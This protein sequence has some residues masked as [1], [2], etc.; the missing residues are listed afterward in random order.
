GT[1]GVEHAADVEVGGC[2]VEHDDYDDGQRDHCPDIQAADVEESQPGQVD[3]P[4]R[5]LV[6][7]YDHAA[8]GL[9][10]DPAKDRQRAESDDD[11]R[12]SAPSHNHSVDRPHYCAHRDGD[13]HSQEWRHFRVV[14]YFHPNDEGSAAD[15]RADRQIDAAGKHDQRLAYRHHRN[16][17]DARRDPIE[18]PVSV[19]AVDHRTEYQDG[20]DDQQEQTELPNLFRPDMS[21]QP[22]HAASPC[23][24]TDWP[25]AAVMIVSS[26]A[27]SRS[28][29]VICRPSRMTSTRSLIAMTSGRS[30]EIMMMPMPSAASS[31]IIACTSAFAPTSIP[32]VGSSRIRR[33]GWVLSHLLN[34]TF[35]W[36]PPESKATGRST[37]GV[38]I[39]NRRRKS[40]A[41]VLSIA[42]LTRPS[43]LRYRFRTG[44]EMLAAIEVGNDSPSCRRSSER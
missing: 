21:L 13:P 16:D 18:G 27:S 10:E 44:S 14:G 2:E 22:V 37:E 7:S 6:G 3:Q 8:E 29:I 9:D 25:M 28:K 20:D 5:Q 42:V 30:E 43:R 36:F 1:H 41:V 33:D 12:Y 11:R 31:P 23:L 26:V 24:W 17:G 19:I 15:D 40:S 34:I 32:R 4:A 39:V 35:C 38:R